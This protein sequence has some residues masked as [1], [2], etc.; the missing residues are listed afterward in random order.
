MP[1]LFL[2]LSRT[3]LGDGGTNRGWRQKTLNRAES[4]M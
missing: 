2:G 3:R 4:G 1:A